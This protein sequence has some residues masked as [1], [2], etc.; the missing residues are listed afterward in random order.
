VGVL[1][2]G[3]WDYVRGGVLAGSYSNCFLVV[4]VEWVGD[5]GEIRTA[6]PVLEPVRKDYSSYRRMRVAGKTFEP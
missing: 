3:A 4:Y 2:T 6:I 5:V 1:D